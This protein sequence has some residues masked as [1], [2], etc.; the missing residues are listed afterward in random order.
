[1]ISVQVQSKQ[2][3]QY[4]DTNVYQKFRG[5]ATL[6]WWLETP[7]WQNNQ[8]GIILF[9]SDWNVKVESKIASGI[10]GIFALGSEPKQET[11]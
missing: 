5:S 1:M 9:V 10:T 11:D 7:C 2:I 8:K 3:N 4:Y 6:L